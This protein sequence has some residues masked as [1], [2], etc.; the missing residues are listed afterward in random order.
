MIEYNLELQKVTKIY[1]RR[2]IFDELDYKFYPA[3]IYGIAG[4]NGAGKSTLSKIILGL[5][6][7][8]KGK[9]FHYFNS[10]TIEPEKLHNH[11]GFTA[12]YLFL[13]DEF[14]AEE[15]LNFFSR[16][17]GVRYDNEKK[18]YLFNKLGLYDRKDDFVKS[19]SSGMKQRLKFIFAIIHSPELILL[20][21]PTSNLD[22]EGKEKVY[23]LLNEQA[24]EKLIII[25]SNDD[26]DLALCSEI[27]DLR[28]YRK[29]L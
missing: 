13:Y 21:E 19:Y 6:S 9:V 26:N 24:N 4:P 16:I 2:L 20:D 5:L 27:I 28:K 3:K 12:P 7:P 18:N 22:N 10:H 11:I 17:R 8:T 23:E 25:A 14:T 1:G 29:D 15:N